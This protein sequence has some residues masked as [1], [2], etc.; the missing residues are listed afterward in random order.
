MEYKPLPIGIENFAE[1]IEQGYY[2]ADKTLFIKELIDKKGKVNLFTRPRRFGKTLC[3][4][5]V[6]HFF[7]KSVKDNAYLFDGLK[8]MDAGEKYA[9]EMG[10]YPV[11]NLS[12]KNVEG[13]SFEQAWDMLRGALRY[14]FRRHGYLLESRNL[15]EGQKALIKAIINNTAQKND[16]PDSFQF[17]TECLEQHHGEKAIVLID[18]YDVPLEK[19]YSGGYYD[20][21]A[22]VIRTLFHTT[23]KTNDSVHFA[24][25]T[26]CLRVSKES[27]FTG[28]N[29]TKIDTIVSDAYG[30][31]FGL[32]EDEVSEAL[33]FYGMEHKLDE[34]RGWYNGYLFG[35]VNVYNPWSIISYLSDLCENPTWYPVSYWA[36]T[37]SNSI[38]RELAE[39]AGDETRDEIEL[40]IQGGNITKPIHEDVVYSEVRQNMDNLWNFLFFTGYLKKTG[41]SFSNNQKYFDLKIPNIEVLTIYERKIREWF[42]DK[43][44]ATGMDKLYGAILGGDSVMFEDE[45]TEML[46]DTISYF[47][48]HENFYHGFL[49]GT[50]ARMKR[51]TV[52][53]NRESGNGRGDIFILPVTMKKAAVI[54]EVKVAD[55]YHGLEKACNMA[56]EQIDAKGYAYEL[57]QTGYTAIIK[58][59]VAFYRKDCMVRRG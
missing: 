44:A 57:E 53:S 47:D 37:S 59:G 6:R 21:M 2:Y 16:Y 42:E 31:Y 8:I 28:F 36:N 50:L 38:V 49:T 46:A 34:A 19:A 30:E 22:N 45:L 9:T 15:Y 12:L 7:E 23:L 26:G 39:L 25:V 32:T 1:M 13:R 35:N 3:L 52:K 41:E 55:T 18:E 33:R 10:K 4:S 24:V 58:Y 11:A 48:S 14:E 29:N 54:L 56:L 5:M 43:V 27:I 51:Y 20:E 40:L 17:L